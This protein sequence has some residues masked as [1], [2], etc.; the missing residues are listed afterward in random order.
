MPTISLDD[1]IVIGESI[2][3]CE[4][5]GELVAL[6]LE[7]GRYFGFDDGGTRIW[8]LIGEHATLRAVLDRLCAEYDA[9]TATLQT[10]LLHF[11]ERLTENGLASATADTTPQ[12]RWVRQAVA[13]PAGPPVSTLR[14]RVCGLL[15]GD[16]SP[17]PVAAE[18]DALLACAREGRVHLLLAAHL[19]AT[20]LLDR[21]PPHVHRALDTALREEARL[22]ELQARDLRLVLA[23]LAA[24]GLKPVLLKGVPLSYTCYPQ[25]YLRPRVDVDVLIRRADVDT[26]HRTMAQLGYARAHL[27]DGERI[28]HQFQYV[29]REPAASAHTYDFHW[30]IANPEVFANLLSYEETSREAVSVPALGPHARALSD[31]HALLFACVHRVAHHYDADD[32]IWL[33]DIH[34][35]ARRLTGDRWW[36]FA[37]MVGDRRM[38]AVCERS[39]ARASDAFGTCVP[40]GIREAFAG[41][42]DEPSAV[43]LGGPL[44][45]IDI[46]RSSFRHLRTWKARWQFVRQHVFPAPRY[47]LDAYQVGNRLWLPAL[48]AH[49]LLRGAVRWLRPLR[50]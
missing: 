19:R 17:L 1:A 50:S 16:E 18:W 12:P 36:E 43:F 41:A 34:L 4:L 31:V 9:P 40:P 8:T 3:F 20:G 48:Y 22:E 49:R 29:T 46:Q 10:D 21:C 24:V 30:Q 44:R 45:Q 13:M 39:L 6:N 38:R 37:H 35:L 32:L 7:T 28:M 47:I 27:I 11:V 42:R 26:V 33:Y 15:G 14:A 2:V 25:P 5:D 23:A